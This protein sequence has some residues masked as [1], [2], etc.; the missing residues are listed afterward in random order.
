MSHKTTSK[1]G[2]HRQKAKWIYPICIVCGKPFPYAASRYAYLEK[3]GKAPRCCSQTCAWE[4]RRMKKE[5][6]A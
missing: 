1:S 3:V 6:A 2:C 4:Y 5:A